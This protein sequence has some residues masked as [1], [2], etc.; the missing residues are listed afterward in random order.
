MTNCTQVM[1]IVFSF[2]LSYY[3]NPLDTLNVVVG[4]VHANDCL[5]DCG[6]LFITQY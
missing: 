6:L 4:D 2:V 1:L 5:I 3:C